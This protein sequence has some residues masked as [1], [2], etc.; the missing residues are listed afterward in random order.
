MTGNPPTMLRSK[1]FLRLFALQVVIVAIFGAAIYFLSVPLIKKTIY[2]QEQT[3]GRTILDNVYELANRIHADLED[4]RKGA[5]DARKRELKNVVSI[6]ASYIRS[7]FAE[8]DK[9]ALTRDQATARVAER[10]RSLRFGKDD[11]IWVVDYDSFS[12]AHPDPKV[13]GTD[14][15]QLRD[16]RGELLIPPMVEIARRS[17]EGYRTY[18]WSRLGASD[19]SEKLAYFMDFPQLGWVIGTGVYMD[20]IDAEVVEK[21]MEAIERLRTSL[22]EIRISKTGY[23]YIFDSG[24][25]M[26]IHPNPN[27]EGKNVAGLENPTTGH[28][29]VRDL[30][31]VADTGDGLVYK[32]DK[33]SDPGNYSYDK[34]SW[35]RHF[36]GFGWYLASSVY[37]EELQRGADVLG[38]RILAITAVVLV[39]ATLLGYVFVGKLTAPIRRLSDTAR[40]VRNGDLSAVSGIQRDDEIGVLSAAFDSMV[41]QLRENID[42]LDIKV[43]E[44]TH[45]LEKANEELKE[46]D[47]MKSGFLSSVSHELRTPLT[48]VRGFAKL[49]AKDFEKVFAPRA[50]GDAKAEKTAS[51]VQ[52][53]LGIILAESDRLTRLID[54]VLDIAKIESGRVAWNEETFRFGDLVQKAARAVEAVFSAS[55]RVSFTVAIEEGLPET[56]ADPDRLTQVIANLLSNAAKF[57]EEGEVELRAW[58]QADGLL[59]VDVRDSGPGIPAMEQ[60]RIFDKFHQ[61]VRDDTLVDKPKGTGLGLAICKEIVE[62]YG[63]RIWV[64]SEVGKGSTFSFVI[65]AK[66]KGTG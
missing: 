7:V 44:R 45:D 34:I 56:A 12:I 26:F 50:Q 39:L 5:I 18:W 1:L 55:P 33:P 52:E 31:A 54:D 15:S 29:L 64:E 57:T 21:K 63:G 11:Y 17:G 66:T 19:P 23:V 27:I 35:V 32:W 38:N 20:D 22:R 43:K 58:R 6:A 41:E 59:R 42:V 14:N 4:Y 48:S 51:R 9:G 25:N 53:N 30:V 61:V 13:N 16:G 28:P 3:A 2:D 37:T 36:K 60:E 10:L 24:M 49:I 65:P 40:R 62:H 46:L 47:R 8:V